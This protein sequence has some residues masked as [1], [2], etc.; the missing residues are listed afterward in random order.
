MNLTQLFTGG[1]SVEDKGYAVLSNS[2][3]RMADVNRQIRSL[4]PGQTIQ[5]E[6]LGK[7]GGEVQIKI[8]GDVVLTARVDQNISLEPGQNIIFEVRSNGNALSLSPLFTNVS[9]DVNVLKAIDMSGLPMNQTTVTMTEQM[10]K[11]GLPVNR[12][13]LHQM[14]RQVNS[15]PGAEVSD[16]V[17]LHRLGMS[18]NE[19]NIQQMASYRNLTHTLTEGMHQVLEALPEAINEML[20]KGNLQDVAELYRTFSAGLSAETESEI[21]SM[22]PEAADKAVTQDAVASQEAAALQEAAQGK[23]AVSETAALDLAALSENIEE[24]AS[25][26]AAP[27]VPGTVQREAIEGM[28]DAI[29]SDTAGGIGDELQNILREFSQVLDL[30]ELP[31]QDKENMAGQLQSIRAGELP[32]EQL[33]RLASELL[34]ATDKQPGNAELIQRLMGDRGLGKMFVAHLKQ[35]W[36]IRPEQV[37]EP[38]RVEELYRHLDRQLKALTGALEAGGQENSAS[39]KAATVLS[40]NIDFLN[41]L[42]QMYTY[43]QLPLQLQRGETQGELYVYTNKRSLAQKEGQVSALLH[44]DMASLGPV[45]VYVT[46]KDTKVN[47]NFYVADEEILHFLEQHMSLLTERLQK[48]GYDCKCTMMTRDTEKGGENDNGQKNSGIAPLLQEGEIL[49]SQHAF[50]VRT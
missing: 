40:Q 43:V 26:G 1:T 11:A 37:A 30:L 4:M 48:R 39:F 36:T 10:M 23:T 49:L 41:Q 31:A 13:A 2:S 5:G 34:S 19:A 42:N 8:S 18:V 6:V 12:N 24:S 20:S 28:P 21:I 38:E 32:A 16:V 15:Y 35:Q 25:D 44:L 46:L 29:F 47:T 33:F 45:D 50:D 14:Y 9:A 27:T 22:L 17:N 3:A 7:N